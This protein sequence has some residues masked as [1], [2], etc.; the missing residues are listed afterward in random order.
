LLIPALSDRI[1][2]VMKKDLHP[3]YK[4]AKVTCGCGNVIETKNTVGD[5]TVEICS[6]CH[7]FF[8]G[9]QKLIDTAGRVDKFKERMEAAEQIKKSKVK[10]QKSGSSKKS[11][12]TETDKSDIKEQ[13]KEIKQEVQDETTDEK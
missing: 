3:E 13:L 12:S 4:K 10:S 9:K 2:L 5:L 7:P 11:N 8:T 6:T 1:A